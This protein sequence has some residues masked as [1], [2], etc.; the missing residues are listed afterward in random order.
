MSSVTGWGWPADLIEGYAPCFRLLR[1][2]RRTARSRGAGAE[3]DMKQQGRTKRTEIPGGKFCNN[4]ST[5][6]L[7]AFLVLDRMLMEFSMRLYNLPR[8]ERLTLRGHHRRLHYAVRRARHGG[9][10]TSR[11]VP[12]CPPKLLQ[13]SREPEVDFG[14]SSRQRCRSRRSKPG[15]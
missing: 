11:F 1:W 7:D 9:A 13:E 15:V 12:V 6:A 3:C 8:R 10:P 4:T 2:S 14:G 5:E